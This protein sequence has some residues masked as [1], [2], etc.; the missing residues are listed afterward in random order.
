MLFTK[1]FST[2]TLKKSKKRFYWVGGI[3]FVIGTL[4]LAMP[5]L[6]SFAVETLCGFLL[7]AVA[8]GNAFGAW[9]AVRGG[10]S[11]WQQ[12]F[13]AVIS[14]AASVIFLT[15]PLAGIMTLSLM[16]SAYFVLDGIAKIAEYVRLRPINGSLWILVSGILSIVLAVMMW[17][18][19]FTGAS[20]IGIILGINFIFSG[21]SLIVLGRGCSEAAKKL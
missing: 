6:A 7:L 11:P 8:A 4:S 18:N 19:F 21:V 2:E 14:F 17:R 9:S 3:M 13:M 12:A 5:L 20:M 1:K 10:G 16:L 15:H